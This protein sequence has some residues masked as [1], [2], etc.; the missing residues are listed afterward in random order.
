VTSRRLVARGLTRLAGLEDRPVPQFARTTLQ[1]WWARRVSGAADAHRPATN[2]TVLLWPDTFTNHFHPH[3]G[4][5]AVEVLESAGWTVTIP[6]EPLCCGLTWISTGQLGTA[7][8]MLR[9]TVR[10]L[11]PHVRSGGL[12]LGLEPSCTS[13]FRSDL[14]ELFPDDQDAHRLAD[15]TV[16]LAELLTERG[17]EVKL[18]WRE[19]GHQLAGGEVEAIAHW[20]KLNPHDEPG[21]PRTT[22]RPCSSAGCDRLRQIG[23][24]IH[25]LVLHLVRGLEDTQLGRKGALGHHHA[26]HGIAQV[27]RLRRG[28]GRRVGGRIRVVA[29]RG[30][31]HIGRLV[32]R[33]DP[34][35]H[36][37]HG[38]YGE[39]HDAGNETAPTEGPTVPVEG[40]AIGD[41]RDH[42]CTLR[43]TGFADAAELRR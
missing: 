22:R 13:V 11:A 40:G 36:R 9:R 21:A 2:G 6:T 33:D 8:R 41:L 43:A 17:A 34:D 15:H 39:Q 16:T 18:D 24:E 20:L 23:R 14:H 25:H 37:H 12:V 4:R 19:A 3:I 10:R 32:E 42:T 28:G 27:V 29:H 1:Q 30:L 7:R 26:D 31:V 35:D 5:A 38:E